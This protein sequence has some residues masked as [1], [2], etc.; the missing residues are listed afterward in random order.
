MKPRAVIVGAV[1]AYA[2]T[3]ACE[4]PPPKPPPVVVGDACERSQ[5]V[6]DHY[7]CPERATP[8]GVRWRAV[9]ERLAGEGYPVPAECV[10][11]ATSCAEA[12]AC[13]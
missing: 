4:P 2:L 3:C 13:R 5:A 9:C 12:R 10:A 6:L 11:H 7:G 8:K 1:L